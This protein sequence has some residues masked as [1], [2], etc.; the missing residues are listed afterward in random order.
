MF[1]AVVKIDFHGCGYYKKMILSNEWGT[2]PIYREWVKREP[3]EFWKVSWPRL[4][5]WK[6]ET[7]HSIIL[8]E[9]SLWRDVMEGNEVRRPT[10]DRKVKESFTDRWGIDFRLGTENPRVLDF[11]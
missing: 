10:N 8:E 11:N 1:A 5:F 4:L 6:W 2:G 9:R 3:L 7:T